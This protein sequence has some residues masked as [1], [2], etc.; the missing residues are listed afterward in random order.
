MIPGG[1]TS[2]PFFTAN[3]SIAPIGE[4]SPYP[5]SLSTHNNIDRF[6]GNY[7]VWSFDG[8]NFQPLMDGKCNAKFFSDLS[9][10]TGNSQ[11]RGMTTVVLDNGFPYL[12]YVI[13]I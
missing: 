7:D 12:A 13:T 2:I 10:A 11:V 4:G 9:L 1:Q 6:I 3:F 8:T 5:Y